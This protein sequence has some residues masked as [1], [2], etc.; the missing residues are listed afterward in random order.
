MHNSPYHSPRASPRGSPRGTLGGSP[1]LSMGRRVGS[2]LGFFY[3]SPRQSGISSGGVGT[4]VLSASPLKKISFAPAQSQNQSQGGNQKPHT[5]V[6]GVGGGFGPGHRHTSSAPV[7]GTPP[8]LPSHQHQQESASS[9]SGGSRGT[10]TGLPGTAS[11]AGGATARGT[12][13]ALYAGAPA[14]HSEKARVTYAM[15]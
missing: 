14:R 5:L 9:M 1:P 8:P 10:P 4:P 7:P 15:N 3:G 13:L 11:S 12:Y 2:P 6:G